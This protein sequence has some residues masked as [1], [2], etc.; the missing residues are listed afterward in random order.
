MTNGALHG[1]DDTA[2]KVGLLMES[3]RS[4]CRV[5]WGLRDDPT[6]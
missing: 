4:S 3:G 5:V 1:I 2:M 6:D